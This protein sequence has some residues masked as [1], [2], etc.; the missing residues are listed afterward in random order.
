[1]DSEIYDPVANTFT[2]TTDPSLGGAAGA[3]LVPVVGQPGKTIAVGRAEH[4]AT[5]LADGRVLIVGGWGFERY[6]PAHPTQLH[7]EEIESCH[8]FDPATNT[9][10]LVPTPL[11]TARERHYATRLPNGTVLI[12]GGFNSNMPFQGQ[13]IDLTLTSAEIYDPA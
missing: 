4:T 2:K 8:V 7:K 3:M 13:T 11:T 12:A 5:R 9:F 1:A 6:D 10:S